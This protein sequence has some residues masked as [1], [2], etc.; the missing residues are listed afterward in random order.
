MRHVSLS[1]YLEATTT[2]DTTILHPAA[3]ATGLGGDFQNTAEIDATQVP[4]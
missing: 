3:A 4:S 1:R 2:A